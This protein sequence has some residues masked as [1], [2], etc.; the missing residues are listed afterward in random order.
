MGVLRRMARTALRAK[1][2]SR[3]VAGGAGAGRVGVVPADGSVGSCAMAITRDIS[4]VV[5]RSVYPQPGP[6]A[7][8]GRVALLAEVLRQQDRAAFLV[9]VRVSGLRALWCR[10]GHGGGA[11]AAAILPFLRDVSLLSSTMS[12]R[13]HWHRQMERVLRTSSSRSSSSSLACNSGLS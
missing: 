8:D 1:G 9:A 3:T 6:R 11:A 12:A 13:R 4:S 7:R 5:V 10:E 2:R